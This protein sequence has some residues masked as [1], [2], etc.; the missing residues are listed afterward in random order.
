LW[1]H[2][3]LNPSASNVSR[4]LAHAGAALTTGTFNLLSKTKSRSAW[5]ARFS[6]SDR[7]RGAHLS[8]K[9][10]VSCLVCCCDL[11][12]LQL[13]ETNLLRLS[14]TVAAVNRQSLLCNFA[15]ALRRDSGTESCAWCER[16]VLISEVEVLRLAFRYP[17]EHIQLPGKPAPNWRPAGGR[18]WLN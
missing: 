11:Q 13:R 17:S 8:S 6:R 10:A 3:D 14:P 12:S 2:S 9:V 5:A 16:S 7:R 1:D 18:F 4:A 15:G